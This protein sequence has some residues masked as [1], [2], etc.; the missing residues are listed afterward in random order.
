M[1]AC[2]SPESGRAR[3]EFSICTM[4]GP[5]RPGVGVGVVGPALVP[6]AARSSATPQASVDTRWLRFLTD[7]TSI[8][9]RDSVARPILWYVQSDV[10]ARNAPDADPGRAFAAQSSDGLAR[11][12][13]RPHHRRHLPLD[14]RR[15]ATEHSLVALLHRRHRLDLWDPGG[16]KPQEPEPRGRPLR[17]VLRYR[18]PLHG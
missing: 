15:G 6:Q 8:R 16:D 13:A 7:G 18:R 3:I 5:G 10:A 2:C 17:A 4:A 14:R 11:S 1:L 9:K 12:L